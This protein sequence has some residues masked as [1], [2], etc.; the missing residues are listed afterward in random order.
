MSKSIKVSDKVYEEL[1]ELQA[2]RETYTEVIDRLLSTIRPLREASKFLGPS[3]Y[4]KE[5]PPCG[6]EGKE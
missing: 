6:K 1:R 5:R 3:H 4:L 2:P